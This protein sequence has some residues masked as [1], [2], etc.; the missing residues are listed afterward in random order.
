MYIMSGACIW[1]TRNHFQFCISRF[2]DLAL[3]RDFNTPYESMRISRIRYCIW[4]FLTYKCKKQRDIQYDQCSPLS[5]QC[6]NCL[7]CLN[8][9][10]SRD[11]GPWSFMA[12]FKWFPLLQDL[13]GLWQLHSSRPHC[14]PQ[15]SLRFQKVLNQ[16]V[17]T[18][19]YK[20]IYLK[21]RKINSVKV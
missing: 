17:D 11:H 19:L 5:K 3:S 9:T 2:Q 20:C 16:A 15:K 1:R 21:I 4:F 7:N 12:V 18:S 6:L 8:W 14:N 10:V 13:A